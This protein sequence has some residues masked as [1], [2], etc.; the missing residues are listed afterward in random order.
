MSDSLLE[1]YL[2]RR[3][4]GRYAHA[5][6]TVTLRV[7]GMAAT[8]ERGFFRCDKCGDER[9]TVEQR[10]SAE[11]AAV[12]AIRAEHGLLAPREIRQLRDRLGLTHQQLGEI[13]YG[14]P[15]GIVE[16]WER[17]RYLQNPQVDALLRSLNDRE[18]LERRAAKAGVQLPVPEGA[19]PEGTV[20]PG[21]A[22]E[23]AVVES[24]AMEGATPDA[25]AP[26]DHPEAGDAAAPDGRDAADAEPALAHR[27]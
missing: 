4:G 5:S 10:E 18:T 12:A 15:R 7:S 6:E 8:V 19:T 9:R 23:G 16:G 2:H 17:G 24:S 1:G 26:A 21:A 22:P 3:C 13:L 14:I 20:P 25:P 11:A 27:G